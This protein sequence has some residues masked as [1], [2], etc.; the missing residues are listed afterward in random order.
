MNPLFAEPLSRADLLALPDAPAGRTVT[1]AVHRN[2]SFE[3]AASV[4]GKFLA[5][6]RVR[7]EYVY[8]D[9]DDSLSFAAVPENA[10]IHLL[11]LD[12]ARYGVADFPAWLESRVLALQAAVGK[13]GGAILAACCGV[14]G[15]ERLSRPGVTALDCDAV[16]A[17]LGAGAYDARLEAFSGTRLSNQACLVLARELGARRI[18][19]LLFPALKALV[20]DLDNTLH[21]GVLAEDGPEG[22]APCL[23]LQEYAA[24]L[25]KQGFLLAL[26]SKN[27]EE[28]V[29]RLFAARK[30]FPLRWEDFAAHAI[31]WGPKSDGVA[32]MA[33][34]LRIGLDAVLFVDDNPGERLEVSRALP[35][36]RI[37]PAS[38]PD[39]MLA[40]LRH[41]PGLYKTRFTPEDALRASDIKANADRDALRRALSPDEYA[42]ELG[43]CLDFAVNPAE[44][45]ARVNELLH[46]TNQ[47]VL[48]LLRPSEAAVA[49]Y[50]TGRGKCVITVSMKDRLSDSG[51]V[52][53]GLFSRAG[54]AL[55]ADELV[56]SCRA[57][58]RGVDDGMLRAMLALA[59]GTL[60]AGPELKIAHATGPRNK[61]A[62]AWLQSLSDRPLAESGTLELDAL[63]GET[64]RSVRIRFEP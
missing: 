20:L 40:A 3:L 9:Y 28:D 44:R 25:G 8:S 23:A 61:P 24:N 13:G 58:G 37:L 1:I 21:R 22:V 55:R 29:R 64:L 36:V 17:P 45:A 47:F 38:E 26:C 35:E 63:P 50:F 10:D 43:I 7:A 16:I 60:R 5:L 4:L 12:A 52:A 59:A 46:K 53:V 57:L 27:E 62:R 33:A 54:E 42:A 30:D 56:I 2:H 31:G 39:E 32:R 6:S 11:W 51:L 19:A 18:P 49:A 15:L 34:T 48:A 14:T 41:Y